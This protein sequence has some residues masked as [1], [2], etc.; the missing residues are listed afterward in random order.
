M[1]TPR[2]EG[3]GQTKTKC[4]RRRKN[5]FQS[6]SLK[7]P[8]PLE[9]PSSRLKGEDERCP[10]EQARLCPHPPSSH[11]PDRTGREVRRSVHNTPRA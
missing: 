3:A 9:A 1:R 7:M 10:K 11:A 5:H 8:M 2:A 6:R 4:R